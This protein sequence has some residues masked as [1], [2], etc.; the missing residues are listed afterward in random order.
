[1]YVLDQKTGRR[2]FLKGAGAAAAGVA[3]VTGAGAAVS[4]QPVAGSEIVPNPA[5]AAGPRER[6]AR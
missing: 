5:G 3:V 1:M 6:P 2:K 4:T